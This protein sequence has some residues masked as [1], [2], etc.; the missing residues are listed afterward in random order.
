VQPVEGPPLII[1]TVEKGIRPAEKPPFQVAQPEQIPL[2]T[3]AH[4]VHAKRR[5]I[6][7]A[8][9]SALVVRSATRS[10][11]QTS[12][13]RAWTAHLRSAIQA[14]V[15]RVL[16]LRPLLM[17]SDARVRLKGRAS[18]SG[19]PGTSVAQDLTRWDCGNDVNDP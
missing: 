15:S 3:S 19:L 13:P 14:A 7:A 10:A 8:L 9:S 5:S 1:Q 16:P 12:W 17:I 6:Q 4:S 11:I 18:S 2:R